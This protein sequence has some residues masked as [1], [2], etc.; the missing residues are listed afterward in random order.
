MPA[1]LSIVIPTLNA[2]DGLARSLP[3]LAAGLMAGLIRDLVVSVS[4]LSERRFFLLIMS[5]ADSGDDN[6][7]A[8]VKHFLEHMRSQS[9]L[10]EQRDEPDRLL[11]VS[12]RV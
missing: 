8:T 3:A 5:S 6:D 2:A 12:V 9:R 11:A 7:I 4:D 1:K 10:A